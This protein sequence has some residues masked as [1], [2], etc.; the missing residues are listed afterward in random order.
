[1]EKSS[2]TMILEEWHCTSF[3]VLQHTE[4]PLCLS[5]HE[6]ARSGLV[7]IL[8]S[9]CTCF[10]FKRMR[11]CSSGH[12]ILHTITAES[13]MFWKEFEHGHTV[14]SKKSGTILHLRLNLTLEKKYNASIFQCFNNINSRY[15]CVWLF[16]VCLIV[17]REYLLALISSTDILRSN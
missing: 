12:I 16:F 8:D 13:M 14:P 4:L 3:L 1:M 7:T 15:R 2:T 9:N 10:Q 11:N 17:K 6:G 5:T